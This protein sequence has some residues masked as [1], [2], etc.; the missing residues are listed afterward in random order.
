MIKQTSSS[1]IK[2][3]ALMMLLFMLIV[4][5]KFVPYRLAINYSNSAPRGLYLMHLSNTGHYKVGDLVVV[6][7][8]DKELADTYIQRKYIST[9]SC[10]FN[11]AYEVKR[12][13]AVQNT[14][15]V[16]Q[17]GIIKFNNT[18]LN[19]FNKDS[20]NR[21]MLS[22][23]KSVVIPAEHYFVVGGVAHSLDSR[24]YGLVDRSFI[25]GYA[26]PLKTW[27]N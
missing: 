27:V 11:T 24:Y 16:V 7:I 5:P 10:E 18:Q 21:P 20:K 9:G 15:I 2:F 8:P 12:I 4:L 13:A 22:K 14:S 19:I 3:K 25:K 23:L 17:N 1:K 6:C 26:Y